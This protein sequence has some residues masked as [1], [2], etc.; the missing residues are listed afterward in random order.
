MPSRQVEAILL[1]L[2]TACSSTPQ[3]TRAREKHEAGPGTVRYAVHV[4]SPSTVS[5]EPVEV[6]DD[7][8]TEVVA[9]LVRSVRPVARPQEEACGVFSQSRELPSEAET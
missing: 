5:V 7:D 2:L 1:M 8:F 9:L 6:D 4:V 3:V